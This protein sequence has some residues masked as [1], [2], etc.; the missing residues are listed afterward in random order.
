MKPVDP[1][2]ILDLTAYERYLDG[3]LEDYEYPAEKVEEAL[4]SLP[5]V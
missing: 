4:A 1:S 3:T 2:E 5:K